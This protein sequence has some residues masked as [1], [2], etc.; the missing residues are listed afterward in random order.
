MDLVIR[1]E[2]APRGTRR[3][4][5]AT[6]VAPSPEVSGKVPYDAVRA[7]KEKLGRI[8]SINKDWMKI[9]EL[10]AEKSIPSCNPSSSGADKRTAG[11][12]S[13]MGIVLR[14]SDF[15]PLATGLPFFEGVVRTEGD[16]G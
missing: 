4:T 13:S 14:T 2:R 7:S 12:T 16:S 5:L 8:T 3:L 9:T 6:V 1:L 11:G 10:T 15:L